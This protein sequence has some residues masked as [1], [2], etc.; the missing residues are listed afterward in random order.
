MSRTRTRFWSFAE[1]ENKSRYGIGVAGWQ[2]GSGGISAITNGS[3]DSMIVG[4]PTST[5]RNL[6]LRVCPT[7]HRIP[8]NGWNSSEVARRDHG[9]GLGD[10]WEKFQERSKDTSSIPLVCGHR[11]S[12]PSDELRRGWLFNRQAVFWLGVTKAANHFEDFAPG[13]EVTPALS[14]VIVHRLHEFDFVA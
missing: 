14:L 10:V 8:L 12:H 1:R 13:R 4:E 7:I 2:C 9:R 11:S 6:S 3:G 5:V